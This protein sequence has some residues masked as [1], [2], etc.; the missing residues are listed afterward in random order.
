METYLG[1]LRKESESDFGVSFPDFP[2]CVTAGRTL[3]EARELAVEALELHIDGMISDGET[4]PTASDLDD[5]MANP[6]NRDG[7]AILVEIRRSKPRA[8]RVNITLDEQ[9][10]REIDEYVEAAGL[11]RSGFLSRAARRELDR[12]G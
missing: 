2:G 7:I 3:E 8:V 11:S 12:T 10:L 6:E 9:T 1:L 5:V 4:M